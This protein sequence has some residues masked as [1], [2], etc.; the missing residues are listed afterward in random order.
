MK[1]IIDMCFIVLIKTLINASFYN[2]Y[3]M[4]MSNTFTPH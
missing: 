3:F 1:G 2:C 4:W